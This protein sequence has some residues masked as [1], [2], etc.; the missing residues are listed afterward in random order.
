[1]GTNQTLIALPMDARIP[2]IQEAL[3]EFSSVIILAEPGAGKS[4]RVPPAL[5]QDGSKSKWI[6]LQPRRWA[7]KQ[8]AKRIAEEQGWN[9]GKEVGYQVRFDSNVSEQTRLTVMTEGILLRKL[10]QDPELSEIQGIILDEFHERSL[11]LDLTLAI[12][13]EIQES[14]RPDLKI[15]VMSATLDPAMLEKFLQRVKTIRV[16]GRTFPVEKKYLGEIPVPTAV[17][18]ALQET[19]GD[20]LVFLPGAFEIEKA[21]RE[22]KGMI[23]AERTIRSEEIEVLPLYSALSDLDQKKIFEPS[24]K[25]RV[26]CSTNIAETS[27]TLPKIEAV[28][29]SG[30]TKVMRSDPQMGEDRL[31]TLRISRASSEQRAGRAGRVKPGICYR[32]WTESEQS[33]LRLFETPEVHRVNLSKAILF[34]ADYGVSDF[35]RFSWFELPRSSMLQWALR[36]LEQFGLIQNGKITERGRGALR[37]PLS[38]KFA[39][40]VMVSDFHQCKE[41]ASRMCAYLENRPAQEE[42]YDGDQ[43]IRKLNQLQGTAQKSAIQ[44]FGKDS[45]PTLAISDQDLYLKILVEAWPDQV[46]VDSRRVGGRRVV[47]KRGHLPRFGFVLNSIE[48]TEKGSPQIEVRS[49]VP[50]D[51]ALVR[52][53]SLKRKIEF[54]DEAQE[55]VRAEE[56][57][58]FQD[59]PIGELREAVA[60]PSH[61]KNVLRE[62]ILK[63]PV[64]VFSRSEYFREWHERVKWFNRMEPFQWSWSE[65]IDSILDSQSSINRLSAVID[66]PVVDYIEGMLESDLVRR[67][68]DEVPEKIEV[69]TGNRIKIDYSGD[70]PKLAV[71]LQEVF[72]WL[73]TPKI[74]GGKVGLLMELLSPGFKPIQITGDLRSFW[75]QAYF[76]VKKELKIRYP[77]HSWPEDPLTAKPEAKGRRRF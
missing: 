2:E 45:V 74:M 24:R 18:K 35:N 42:I 25:R 6:M 19:E 64:A 62:F 20:I 63:D 46:F 60:D 4:T 7:A 48:K 34:L 32:L 39:Q 66:A 52:S 29:D 75:S 16:E 36:E 5:I 61:A 68:H 15:V 72:G 40:L 44:I 10:V 56:G 71:R 49:Y 38:P 26:I 31:E 12:L 59:L 30:W 22:I 76:E 77:K 51:E 55:K 70:V 65:L 53:K 58:F 57:F 50:L 69:P 3:S 21:V 1:M 54:W 73:D 37:Y 28:V 23:P 27:I 14:L 67:F 9:L 47:S 43:L 33:Q 8:V 13:K 11:D 17:K 41:F